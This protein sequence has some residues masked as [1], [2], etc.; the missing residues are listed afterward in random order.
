MLW[1]EY[2]YEDFTIVQWF[3]LAMSLTVF[4]PFSIVLAVSFLLYKIFGFDRQYFSIDNSI[5]DF[6]CWYFDYFLKLPIRY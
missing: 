1:D 5:T 4:I 2:R 6:S 3:F